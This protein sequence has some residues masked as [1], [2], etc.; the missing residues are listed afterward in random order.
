M[1]KLTGMMV[2]GGLLIGASL[3]TTTMAQRPGGGGRDGGPRPAGGDDFVGRMMEFDQDKDGKI[4]R[5]EVTDIRLVR[6]WER[7]DANDDGS[8]TKDELTA[9]AAREQVND[10]GGPGGF[11]G[12]GGPPGGG[13]PGG[14]RGGFRPG[15]PGEVLPAMLQQ[16]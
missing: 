1:W 14:G 9:L 7:A 3:A 2:A 8:V 16:A 5:A 15:R 13:P 10:R 11:G 4:T 12:P 6:L